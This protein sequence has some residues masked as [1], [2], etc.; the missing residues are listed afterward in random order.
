MSAWLSHIS[1][2]VEKQELRQQGFLLFI[3]LP[4]AGGECREKRGRQAGWSVAAAHGGGEWGC[5]WKRKKGG[6]R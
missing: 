6:R 2:G 1:S 4:F 3:F 5:E